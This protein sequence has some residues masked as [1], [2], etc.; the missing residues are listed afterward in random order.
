MD[1]RTD[2]RTIR[3]SDALNLGGGLKYSDKSLQRWSASNLYQSRSL[4]LHKTAENILYNQ[5]LRADNP[6][7][8][9]VETL[10]ARA[11]LHVHRHYCDTLQP[12]N[13]YRNVRIATSSFIFFLLE[14]AN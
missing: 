6:R 4:D 1:G 9:H 3:Q 8:I 5:Q 7:R 2:G 11:C 12:T 13:V 14:N 10:R